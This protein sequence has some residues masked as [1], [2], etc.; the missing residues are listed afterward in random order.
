MRRC[1]SGAVEAWAGCGVAVP[2]TAIA[3]GE[4]LAV[5]RELGIGPIGGG[6]SR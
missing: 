1:C 5:V 2:W 3:E 4:P 6:E